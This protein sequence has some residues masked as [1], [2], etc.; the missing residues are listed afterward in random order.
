MTKEFTSVPCS[1]ATTTPCT[2]LL[3][4]Q[5]NSAPTQP[6]GVCVNILNGGIAMHLTDVNVQN[7]PPLPLL[8]N[9]TAAI[10]KNKP[11]LF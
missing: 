7:A 3:V 11:G 2:Q 6:P 10:A 1:A 4:Y 9:F 5:L 8:S